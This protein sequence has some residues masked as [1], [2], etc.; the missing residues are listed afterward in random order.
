MSMTLHDVVRLVEQER[1]AAKRQHATGNRVLN[2]K[3]TNKG[4]HDLNARGFDPRRIL[5]G[6]ATA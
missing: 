1:T 6:K 2:N 3:P 4:L 5:T